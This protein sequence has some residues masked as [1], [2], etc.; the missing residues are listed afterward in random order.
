[1][2]GGLYRFGGKFFGVS[3]IASYRRRSFQSF[4]ILFE[5]IVPAEETDILQYFPP[6]TATTSGYTLSYGDGILL[7]KNTVKRL[8]KIGMVKKKYLSFFE[9]AYNTYRGSRR[10]WFGLSMHEVENIIEAGGLLP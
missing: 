8:K 9:A 6:G 4:A 1:M 7:Y 10:T 3:L 5:G 2:V